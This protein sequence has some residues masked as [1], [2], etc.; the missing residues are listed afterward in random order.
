M[1]PNNN[2]SFSSLLWLSKLLKSQRTSEK[3]SEQGLS[4]LE[5]LIGMLIISIAISAITPTLLLGAAT[6]IQNRRSEQAFNIAREQV[7]QIKLL[8][9]QDEYNNT[10]LPPEANITNADDITTVNAPN[11]ICTNPNDSSPCDAEK[12]FRQGDFLVQTFRNPGIKDNND[13]II[14]FRMGVRVY[15]KSAE[16]QLG[17]LE[18]KKARLILSSGEG[19]KLQQQPLVVVYTELPQS[20]FPGSLDKYREFLG[21]GN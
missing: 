20:D 3:T 2:S 13:K 19:T 12:F 8:L 17:N 16:Q 7:E 9:D 15:Y 21:N 14:A 6:R 11:S 4:L 1:R 18:T 5:V 10:D